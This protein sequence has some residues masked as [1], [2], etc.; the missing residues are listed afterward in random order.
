MA[1]RVRAKCAD[2]AGM[3][4]MAQTVAAE[5]GSTQYLTPRYYGLDFEKSKPRCRAYIRVEP[6]GEVWQHSQF[7]NDGPNGPEE[8]KQ[9][10]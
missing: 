5:E 6:N 7:E 4:R 9:L 2:R 3:I 10:A 8:P 1:G